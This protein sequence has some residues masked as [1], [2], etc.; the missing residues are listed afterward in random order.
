MDRKAPSQAAVN[1]LFTSIRCPIRSRCVPTACAM[2]V[3]L[4]PD[5]GLLRSRSTRKAVTPGK[6]NKLLENSYGGRLVEDA[7]TFVVR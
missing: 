2:W 3:D 7:G 1:A 5:L 6:M 4:H